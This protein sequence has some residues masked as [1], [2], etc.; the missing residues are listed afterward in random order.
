MGGNQMKRTT[1]ASFLLELPLKLD[2]STEKPLRAHLEAARCLYNALLS[3]ANKR[4]RA[5]RHD[6][7]WQAACALPHTKKLERAQAFSALRKKH[8]FSEYDLH[9]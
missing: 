8:H 2:W 1:T 5:M 4:L 3:E 9:E 7:S 6:P